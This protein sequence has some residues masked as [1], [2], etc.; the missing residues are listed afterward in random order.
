M[1]S[2]FLSEQEPDRAGIQPVEL[3]PGTPDMADIAGTVGMAGIGSERVP[4]PGLALAPEA[5]QV[6]VLGPE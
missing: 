2:V 6:S 5:V 4:V 3:L 1:V